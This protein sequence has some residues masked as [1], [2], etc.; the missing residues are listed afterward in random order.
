[1]RLGVRFFPIHQGPR[2]LQE[3]VHSGWWK[4]Q[5][6]TV[7]F[8][9]SGTVF[10]CYVEQQT[11]KFEPWTKI[12]PAIVYDLEVPMVQ[13]TV[14]I[15]ENTAVNFSLGLLIQ[16]RCPTLLVGQAGTGKTQLMLGK[17]HK[18]QAES[19]G[20]YSLSTIN[21]NHYTDAEAL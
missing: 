6:K 7:E 4:S 5:F 16:C 11:G 21:F 13:V 19:D 15:P 17:L 14:P 9:T 18:M 1:V 2:R 12:V 3:G 8:P 10:D 20:N